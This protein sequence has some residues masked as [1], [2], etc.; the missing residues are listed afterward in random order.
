MNQEEQ[1]ITI[2]SFLLD[3]EIELEQFKEWVECNG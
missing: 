2:K 1:D 3:L